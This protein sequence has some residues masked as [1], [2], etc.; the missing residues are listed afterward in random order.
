MPLK[1]LPMCRQEGI[2]YWTLVG[3]LRSGKLAPPAKDS[4]GDYVWTP[5]DIVRVR[6][7]LATIQRRKPKNISEVVNGL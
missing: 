4:S 5:E 2:G 7:A 6:A 1:T 3:L